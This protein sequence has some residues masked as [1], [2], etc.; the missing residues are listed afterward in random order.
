[1]AGGLSLA[2][3]YYLESVK[4][5]ASGGAGTDETDDEVLKRPIAILGAGAERAPV[6]QSASLLREPPFQA[7]PV[8]RWKSELACQTADGRAWEIAV[9]AALYHADLTGGLAASP[10]PFFVEKDFLSTLLYAWSS[11][12]VV[13]TMALV[14][15]ECSIP[16]PSAIVYADVRTEGGVPGPAQAIA[17]P[18]GERRLA[19][20]VDFY[21]A[22]GIPVIRAS[23]HVSNR[24]ALQAARA[25][26]VQTPMRITEADVWQ[27]AAACKSLDIM[28]PC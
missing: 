17:A 28:A 16:L 4:M 5:R 27:I 2:V 23:E 15:R 8:A 25:L 18:D 13:Q 21:G 12:A 6:C 20:L 1:M 3:Y 26:S 7:Q 24:D 11:S 22:H 14:A 10:E 9:H 19:A